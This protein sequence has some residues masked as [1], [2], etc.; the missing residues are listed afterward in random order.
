MIGFVV[1]PA[2]GNG[3]TGREWPKIERAI[4]E[5]FAHSYRAI[6]TEYPIHAMEITRNLLREKVDKIVAVGGDGTLN[7][8]VNG[9]F[10]QGRPINPRASLGI[11][12]LGTGADFIRTLHW[13]G[14]IYQALERIAHAH[15]RSIDL[16]HASFLDLNG[17]QRQRYFINIADFGLGG[18]V[19]DRV[20][21]TSKIFGGKVSFLWGILTT[22]FRY[23]NKSITFRIE[24]G[25]WHMETMNIFVVGNGRYF[26]GGLNP[27]PMA[28]LDDG[29]LDMV[30][31]GDTTFVEV[32]KNLANLR[33]G[34]HLGHPKVNIYRAR[35]MEAHSQETVYIDLDGECV[36]CLPIEIEIVPKALR[37]FE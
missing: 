31:V 36:G 27:T 2:S 28:Q 35:R 5:R 33:K 21:R 13:P 18:A 9:F 10:D 8:V 19:V 26:G 29:Q 22:L 23:K 30:T 16:G 17:N 3:K 15:I 1:N 12:C 6:F 4:A 7:E 24:G 34:T 20:N 25:P 32:I 11:L 37:I 14:D